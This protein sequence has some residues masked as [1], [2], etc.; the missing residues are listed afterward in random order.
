MIKLYIPK[1][2]WLF[3][4]QYDLVDQEGQIVYRH[5]SNLFRTKRFIANRD[6]EAVLFSKTVFGRKDN[7]AIIENNEIIA[8]ISNKPGLGN[9]ILISKDGYR[10]KVEERMRFSISD[11]HGIVLTIAKSD[12]KDS[13]YSVSV[14]EDQRDFLIMLMFT[15]MVMLDKLFPSN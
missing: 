5:R 11:T 13:S 15:I 2:K 14:K 7:H 8:Y 10:V 6:N 3:N 12:R 4:D 1:K 9:V